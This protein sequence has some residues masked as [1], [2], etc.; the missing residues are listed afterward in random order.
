MRVAGI[1]FRQAATLASLYGALARL[2]QPD[3]LAT[4]IAKAKA[5]VILDL[6]HQLGLPLLAVDV[7]GIATA[8]RS[9]RVVLMHGTGSVAEA[10]ALA[11]L[12]PGASLIFPRVTS[13]DGMATAAMA[14]GDPI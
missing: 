8:T 2:G 13:Q 14:E 3:A 11:A 5:A 6:A 9:P 7:A 12:A 4:A 10:A 1:G